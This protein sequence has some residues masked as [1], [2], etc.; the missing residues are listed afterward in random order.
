ML[1]SRLIFHLLPAYIVESITGVAKP[2]NP[3][4]WALRIVRGEQL[5]AALI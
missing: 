2:R 5:Q 4:A 3:I 1:F